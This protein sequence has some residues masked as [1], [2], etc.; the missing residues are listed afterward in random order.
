MLRNL[1]AA[2]VAAGMLVSSATV[3]MA[4]TDANKGALAPGKA[5]GVQKAEVFSGDTGLYIL[6]GAVVVGGIVLVSSGSS[7][8]HGGTSTTTTASP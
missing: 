8:H 7:N 2:V 4:G 1:G 3:A 5:A 6:G